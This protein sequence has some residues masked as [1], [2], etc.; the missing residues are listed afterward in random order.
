LLTTQ[1]GIINRR[2]DCT[3][4]RVKSEEWDD[5]KTIDC[6]SVA[7]IRQVIEAL[8]GAIDKMSVD[9]RGLVEATDSS[10]AI[11]AKYTV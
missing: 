4:A 11:L 9:M 3:G 8:P 1:D 10:L 2:R 6:L 7:H 5:D